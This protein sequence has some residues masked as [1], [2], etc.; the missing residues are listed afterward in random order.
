MLRARDAVLK[1]KEYHPPLGN[2][3]GLRL[4]FNENTSGCSPRVLQKLRSLDGETLA[5]YTYNTQHL[6]LTYRRGRPNDKL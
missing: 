2:R 5:R 4:D 6:P 3:E 1:M